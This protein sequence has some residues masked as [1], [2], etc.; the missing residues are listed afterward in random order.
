MTIVGP[1]QITDLL[2]LGGPLELLFCQ[3]G[4]LP[5]KPPL[6][7]GPPPLGGP[8]LLLNPPLASEPRPAYRGLFP[9]P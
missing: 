2:L 6:L 1:V 8:P 4:R 7:G 5:W 9:P 3:G